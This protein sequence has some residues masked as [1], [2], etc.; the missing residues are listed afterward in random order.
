MNWIYRQLFR[1]GDWIFQAYCYFV[2]PTRRGAY[3]AVWWDRRILLIK[4]SY[5]TALT[6]PSGGI[7]TNETPRNGARRELKEEVGISADVDKFR[8][9]S[10]FI[11]DHD[12]IHDEVFAFELIFDHQPDIQIDN[13]EVTVARFEQLDEALTLNLSAVAARILQSYAQ[14]DSYHSFRRIAIGGTKDAYSR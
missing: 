1:I 5:R 7:G 11:L 2:Q 14:S 9:L 4:N 8:F 12:N 10:R 3:V 6:L 13:R